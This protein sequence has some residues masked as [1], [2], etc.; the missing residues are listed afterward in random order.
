MKKS[1]KLFGAILLLISVSLSSCKSDQQK[2]EQVQQPLPENMKGIKELP[3][4][5]PTIQC[6]VCQGSG[7]TICPY[8]DGSGR[9]MLTQRLD[10][11]TIVDDKVVDCPE[12]SGY[13]TV[14]CRTC[15]G[16]G[17]IESNSGSARK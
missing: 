15:G 5:K 3:S 10:D 16:S 2:Q 17:K 11:G 8:C 6:D 13:G 14:E 9:R 7:K 1:I 4:G 12:C